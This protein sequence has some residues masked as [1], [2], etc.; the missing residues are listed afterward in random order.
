MQARLIKRWEEDATRWTQAEKNAIRFARTYA[1]AP[2]KLFCVHAK[3]T[4][5][6]GEK[7]AM[8]IAQGLAVAVEQPSEVKE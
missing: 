7:A 6:E 2:T 8:L 4:I 5:F 3:G 1:E